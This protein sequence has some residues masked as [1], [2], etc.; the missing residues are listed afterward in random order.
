MKTRE[1]E[2]YLHIPFCKKKC[3]YCDF[4]SFP[5]GDDEISSYIRKLRQEILH[6]GRLLKRPSVSTVFIGGGTPSLIPGAQIE[7]LMNTVRDSFSCAENM[8]CT[9]EAN[10]GTVTREKL[11]AYQNCGIN[12]ISFGLQSARE[13]ELKILGR[14]HTFEDFVSGFYMARDC[15]FQNINV[16]LMNAVPMQT[17]E[18]MEQTLLKTAELEPEHLSVYSLII[19]EGTPF[20]DMKGLDDLLPTEDEDAA[21]YERTEKILH[22]LGYE[23]YE[24]SN[25]ARPGYECRHNCGYWTGKP[26]L[27]IWFG[28]VFLF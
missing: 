26:Y 7:S 28:G 4:C 12:R 15:G 16:D 2:L 10:P 22:T 1:L 5:A 25:Y 6:W 17:M 11:S 9:I 13:E 8:E 20:Y 19:E 27:G 18:S 23:R 21:M 3:S 24:L 14:I